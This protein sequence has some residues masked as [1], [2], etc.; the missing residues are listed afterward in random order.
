QQAAWAISRHAKMFR[1][2]ERGSKADRFRFVRGETNDNRLVGSRNESLT[3]IRDTILLIL[4]VS[5]SVP[6]VQLAPIAA[7]VLFTAGE[8]D[9]QSAQGLVS[10]ILNLFS[11]SAGCTGALASEVYINQFLGF[12][13]FSREK[14]T[15]NLWQVLR[16]VWPVRILDRTRPQ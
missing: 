16:C 9:F 11:V 6:N 4:N 1:T 13:V 15:T 3:R 5:D 10:T 2:I 7:D 14:E 8:V 12:R